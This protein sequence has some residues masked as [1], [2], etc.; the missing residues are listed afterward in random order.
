MLVIDVDGLTKTF[1]TF[2]RREGVRGAVLDLFHRE[3]REV[4]AVSDIGFGVQEGEIVGYI[5]PNG[6]GKSTTIKMLTGILRPTAG[7]ISVLGMTP[8]ARRS[9]YTRKIGVVFGQRTQLWWDIAVIEAY[10]LLRRVYQIPEA[11]YRRRLGFFTE[12]LELGEFLHLPVRKLSLGQRMRADLAAS[13]LHNPPLLFLDEPTIGLDVDVKLRIRDFIRAVNREQE[14][15]VLLTTHDLGDIEE[16]CPRVLIMDHGRIVYD[17]LL[18]RLRESHGR[19][20]RVVFEFRDPVSVA[21]LQESLAGLAPAAETATVTGSADK[22]LEVAFDRAKTTAADVIDRVIAAFDV[23][24]LSV[25]EPDL[26]EIIAGI[27]RGR[28]GYEEREGSGE[29]EKHEGGEGGPC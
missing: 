5:G 22:R 10:H 6:A 25:R 4:R 2:R 16:L 7:R 19:E 27:Y 28:G 1:R 14:T 26:T 29:R 17:G 8:W 23:K 21:M 9:E 24:D 18:E 12:L 11:D 13:L 20:R 15:T 3:Y